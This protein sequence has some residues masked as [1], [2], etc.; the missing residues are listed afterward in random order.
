VH[1]TI[2][3][4]QID[5]TGQPIEVDTG[6]DLR[7][8]DLGHDD[9][10]SVSG[11]HITVTASKGNQP[12]EYVVEGRFRFMADLL[13]SRCLEP[14]PFASE[15][16]FAVRF[17]PHPSVDSAD[18]EIEIEEGDLEVEHYTEPVLSLER[19]AAEQLELALP[20]KLLCDERCL[21][22]CA[23]CGANLRTKPCDCGRNE[24]DERWQSLASLRD[25]L[26]KKEH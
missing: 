21:G 5:E 23:S 13:C 1:P 16:E 10:D 9:I 11:V 20:M 24:V 15:S 14:V 12:G 2:D 25:E 6:I 7:V 17:R 3:F 8:D 19:L 18:H 22:L 4:H 26:S